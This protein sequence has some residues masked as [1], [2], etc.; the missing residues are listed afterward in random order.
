MFLKGDTISIRALEPSDAELLY[1]WENN[2]ELW[3]VSYTQIPF[4]KFILE[5]FVSASRHDIYTEKQLRLMI[6]A[7]DSGKT[8]GI[9]DLFE[10]DPQHARCGLGIFIHDDYRQKGAAIECVELI[11]QYCFS[12]LFLKQI[13]VHVKSS[14][15]AS[16]ALFEKAGFEKIALKKSWIKIGIDTYEDVWFLQLINA[17][18]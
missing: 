18:F 6:N 12:I 11:K 7:N 4:S 5:E 1:T 8:I 15:P 16:L 10:F 2:L 13:Y 17:G 9:I 14:N 3:P